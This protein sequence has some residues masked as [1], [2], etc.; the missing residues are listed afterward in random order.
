MASN[1]MRAEGESDEDFRKKT[2]FEYKQRA[3]NNLD[4][5][6]FELD[7]DDITTAC[8]YINST[9]PQYAS[10]GA[11]F[12]ELR[13]RVWETVNTNIGVFFEEANDT[14]EGADEDIVSTIWESLK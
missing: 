12:T 14:I 1:L 9:N 3:K 7:Y 4:G 11:K 6:A 5:K 10:E 8:S 2:A 13:D